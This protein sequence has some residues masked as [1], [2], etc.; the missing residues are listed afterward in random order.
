VGDLIYNRP[1]M[2]IRITE[3]EREPQFFGELKEILYVP[4]ETVNG[5]SEI[6]STEQF[7]VLPDRYTEMRLPPGELYLV[8]SDWM[9]DENEDLIYETCEITATLPFTVT[10]PRVQFWYDP[11]DPYDI[12]VNDEL[13][14][15]LPITVR[16][17][18]YP[19]QGP[20]QA[21]HYLLLD[22][23]ATI[24]IM[25]DTGVLGNYTGMLV[26]ITGCLYDTV[27]CPPGVRIDD[28][29]NI[30]PLGPLTPTPT[31]TS[32][33]TRTR[34]TTPT[35]TRTSTSDIPGGTATPTATPTTTA[36]GPVGP[37]QT[38][39]PGTGHISGMVQLEGRVDYSG[40]SVSVPGVP[41]ANTLTDASGAFTIYDV[42]VGIHT[43]VA[44]INRYLFA[45][46]SDVN[47]V[48]GVTTSLPDVLLRGGDANDDDTVDIFDLVILGLAYNSTP[49]DP[50]WDPRGDINDDNAVNLWDLVLVGTNYNKTAPTDWSLLAQAKSQA[51]VVPAKA[52]MALQQEGSEMLLEIKVADATELYGAELELA[53]DPLRLQVQDVDPNRAGVQ[54]A[55]GDLFDADSAYVVENSVDNAKGLVRYAV[56][57][58]RPAEPVSGQ[59]VLLR[60]RFKAQ[61]SP[62][63]IIDLKS[64]SLYNKASEDMQVLSDKLLVKPAVDAS[65]LPSLFLKDN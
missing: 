25:D 24:N 59:G 14:D 64:L 11:T 63:T 62:K 1:P 2:N 46:K 53:F 39:Q 55:Q 36:T 33:A 13:V 28:P 4:T 9:S 21:T 60:L 30:T 43:I 12:Y 34:T 49:G 52:E 7:N 57:L 65:R 5:L 26:E 18:V 10:N 29:G 44:D 22:S 56:T 27:V 41:G 8:T 50:D 31:N 35:P 42:P 15:C 23:G 45:Q 37:T 17:I 19:Y 51:K 20:C 48:N 61:G 47:V 38:P 54:V 58:L 40:A 16:G 3:E 6:W 32:E